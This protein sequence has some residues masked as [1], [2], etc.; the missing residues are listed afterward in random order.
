VA[1]KQARPVVVVLVGEEFK[2]LK[3]Q[4]PRGSDMREAGKGGRPAE[5]QNRSLILSG[6]RGGLQVRGQ[7]STPTDILPI[8]VLLQ[9][10]KGTLSGRTT[11]HGADHPVTRFPYSGYHGCD[12]AFDRILH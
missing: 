1:A 12:D 5:G 7:C 8:S 10:P 3:A 11:F 9:A 4:R 6:L 2:R